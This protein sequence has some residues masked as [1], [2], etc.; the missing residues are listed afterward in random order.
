MSNYVTDIEKYLGRKVDIVLVNNESPSEEQVIQYKVKEGD[1][2]LTEDD[3]GNDVRV[4]R[5]NLLSHAIVKHNPA[6]KIQSVRSFIRHD[7]DK[8]RDA[9][10]KII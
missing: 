1:G 2:V 4:I 6:D 10:G 7:R 5:E 3:M 8:F 9:I